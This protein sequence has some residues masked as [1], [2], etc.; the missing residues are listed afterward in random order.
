MWA[1]T[2]L[3]IITSIIYGFMYDSTWWRLYGI[4]VLV[5]YIVT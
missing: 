1:L 3:A 5:Y 4:V 2:T